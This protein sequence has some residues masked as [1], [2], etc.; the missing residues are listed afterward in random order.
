MTTFWQRFVTSS[1]EGPSIRPQNLDEVLRGRR[2]VRSFRA[3][4][5]PASVISDAI[6]N[7]GWA[8]SPHGRQPWRFVVLESLEKRTE[9]A[10]AMSRTW[11][12]QLELDGQDAETIAIRVGKSRDRLLDP[13]FVIIV[14]LYV[15]EMDH[16]PDADRNA[17][18][19]IMAVQSL[20]S[21][22]Q[23]FLLS[24]W[25]SGYD[26]GW[27]CAP[28]FCPEIVRETL[29]LAAEL[30]PHAMIPVGIAAKDPVRRPRRAVDDLIVDW[31]R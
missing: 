16:Y 6:E 8:P 10:D 18:E 25:A 30:E 9:L 31:W 29:G 19:R 1:D 27:M 26:A 4:P 28:L 5:I 17:A 22:V 3:D 23:D 14:C 11:R 15:A 2:S 12:E 24:I 7:A 13:P 20:G 21:A